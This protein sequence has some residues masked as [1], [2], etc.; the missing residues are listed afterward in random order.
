MRQADEYRS[1][2]VQ[3]WFRSLLAEAYVST[4]RLDVASEVANAALQLST[5]TNF[6]YIAAGAQRALGWIAQARGDLAEAEARFKESLN[7][8]APTE[9]RSWPAQMHLDFAAL[10]H[11]RRD[12]DLVS[13]HLREAY[14]GFKGIRTPR[15]IER[16]EQLAREFDVPLPS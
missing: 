15:W 7:I 6:L 3:A 2:Q 12:R 13:A 16:T 1:R 9:S 4:G 10:A 8:S 11:A 5:E 14:S